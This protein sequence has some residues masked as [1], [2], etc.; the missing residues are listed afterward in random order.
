MA[1]GVR[2]ESHQFQDIGYLYIE[3]T[4]TALVGDVPRKLILSEKYEQDR[5][6]GEPFDHQRSSCRNTDR[7]PDDPLYECGPDWI[8]S[9][10]TAGDR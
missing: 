8:H 10:Q 2:N 5:R 4:Y 6:A 7:E 3:T 1:V 9:R